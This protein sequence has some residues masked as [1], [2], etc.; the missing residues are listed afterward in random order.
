MTKLKHG[1]VDVVIGGK[2]A[3]AGTAI[4]IGAPAVTVGGVPGAPAPGTGAG[5]DTAHRRGGVGVRFFVARIARGAE[6]GALI[7]PSCN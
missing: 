6:A 7:R 4:M 1:A 3:Q 5:A 2:E